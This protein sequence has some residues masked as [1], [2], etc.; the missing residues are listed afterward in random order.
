MTSRREL[1]EQLR[2]AW[3]ELRSADRTIAALAA[4]VEEHERLSGVVVGMRNGRAVL[5]AS[6]GEWPAPA[7]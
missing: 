3:E 7:L 4:M 5:I 1:K 6:A 2:L